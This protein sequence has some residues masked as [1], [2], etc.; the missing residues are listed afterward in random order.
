MNLTKEL[1]RARHR[2][3]LAP[4][5]LEDRVVMSA[6]QGSTFAIMPGTVT[7]AG[8]V[9]IVN[10]KID[11]TMFT[12]PKRNGDI[13]DRASTS[14]RRRP[15]ARRRA[16][17]PTLK[18]RDRLGH[19]CIGSRDPRPAYK[20]RPQGRQGEQAGQYPDL[21]RTGDAQGS[22][23]RD[24]RRPTT[25]CRSRGCS[26]PRASTWSASTSGR[27]RRHRARSP[28][29]TFRRSRKTTG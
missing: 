19:G 26:R 14:P 4:E 11:P 22:S 21:G 28:S 20:V 6:G 24:S 2:M 25:R 15:P 27:R 3:C 1:R 13:V 17:R 12:S 16:R 10:F 29:R 23:D 5:V 9:S 8:Q 7:T 18:P